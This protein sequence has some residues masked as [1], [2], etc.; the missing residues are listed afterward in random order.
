VREPRD[1]S[2][3]ARETVDT[4][5]VPIILTNKW[6]TVFG[7]AN[8]RLNPKAP[9]SGAT[10]GQGQ[11]CGQGDRRG[12]FGEEDAHGVFWHIPGRRSSQ[13]GF[14]D[15]DAVSAAANSASSR[16]D[17]TFSGLRVKGTWMGRSPCPGA[18]GWI[19]E[20][21]HL[22]LVAF[23]QAQGPELQEASN[24]HT[25]LSA[26]WHAGTCAAMVCRHSFEKL[27]ALNLTL[28]LPLVVL[29]FI[30]TCFFGSNSKLRL[31]LGFN[32]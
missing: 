32:Q 25:S 5:R 16:G 27:K 13:H 12:A 11:T 6:L 14:S 8:V 4:L 21:R 31:P 2:D 1:V 22:P 30:V 29:H 19:D 20:R 26:S 9:G 15:S 28:L 3:W 10:D 23:R 24:R 18:P 17:A 7:F